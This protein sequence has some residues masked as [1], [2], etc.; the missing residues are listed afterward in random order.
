MAAPAALVTAPLPI[1]LRRDHVD[2]AEDRDHIA[3]HVA[4]HHLR[5]A[6]VVDVAAR[7]RAGAPGAVVAVADDVISQLA[8]RAL[9]TAVDF[10]PRGLE[11]AVGHDQLEVLDQAFDAAVDLF[12]WRQ[13]VLAFGADVHRA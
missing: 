10:A 2:A 6:L 13:D 7:P 4:F 11:P 9:D 5:E 8:V 1:Q 3:D 12:L